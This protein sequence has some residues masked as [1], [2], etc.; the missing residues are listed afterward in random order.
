MVVFEDMRNKESSSA[1]QSA[2]EDVAGGQ[3]ADRVPSKDIV[4]YIVASE[5]VHIQQ[6]WYRPSEP[7]PEAC[8]PFYSSATCVPSRGATPLSG[9]QPDWW[10][11]PE[12]C[13]TAGVRLGPLHYFNDCR[14]LKPRKGARGKTA[15]LAVSAELAGILPFTTYCSAC[16]KRLELS[17]PPGPDARLRQRAG[18]EERNR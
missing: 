14:F 10:V 8:T 17:Q 6:R 11:E 3:S 13:T 15:T 4:G 1:Q 9:Q 5:I 12:K 18:I 2:G 7:R 16:L